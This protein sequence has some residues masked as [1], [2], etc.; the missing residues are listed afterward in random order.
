MQLELR[1]C[2]SSRDDVG[3]NDVL[4]IGATDWTDGEREGAGDAG[5]HVGA[6]QQHDAQLCVHADLAQSALS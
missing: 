2:G 5:G 1:C 4:D 6:R 3:F